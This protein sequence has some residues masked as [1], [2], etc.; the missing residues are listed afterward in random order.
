MIRRQKEHNHVKSD[1]PLNGTGCLNAIEIISQDE[2]YNKGR[3]FN[4]VTLKKGSS[5]G[6]HFHNDEQEI[7]HILEG[8]ATYHDNGV[9]KLIEKGDTTICLSGEC[10]G[11]SNESDDDLVFIALILNK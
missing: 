6:I 8:K 3:M 10:H 4:I 5:V 7:Y 11:I 9:D 2:F 1:N